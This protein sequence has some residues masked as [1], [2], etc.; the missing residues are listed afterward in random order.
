MENSALGT[1]SNRGPPAIGVPTPSRHPTACCPTQPRLAAAACSASRTCQEGPPLGV[2]TPHAAA[3]PR[4]CSRTSPGSRGPHPGA[5]VQPCLQRTVP[6]PLSSHLPFLGLI[7]SLFALS[8]M[9]QLCKLSFL[10]E[11]LKPDVRNTRAPPYLETRARY[12]N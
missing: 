1:P 4:A 5:G 12:K 3:P 7:F 10:P 11:E 2:P 8:V 9:C 6:P